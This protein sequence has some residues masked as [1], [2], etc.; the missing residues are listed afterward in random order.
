V[1][2]MAPAVAA[3]HDAQPAPGCAGRAGTGAEYGRVV[4][5]TVSRRVPLAT[6]PALCRLATV[7]RPTR[8]V[9][10]DHRA[11]RSA[12]CADNR[13]ELKEEMWIWTM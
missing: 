7:V 8:Q 10:R 4:A 1:T 5:V 13:G 3:V 2:T 9:P 11:V 12:E 6:R